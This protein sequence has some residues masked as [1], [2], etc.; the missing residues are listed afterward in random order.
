M[1]VRYRTLALVVIGM[2]SPAAGQNTQQTT[3][4]KQLLVDPPG[5]RLEQPS[6][7][8]QR[9]VADTISEASVSEIDASRNAYLVDRGN[10]IVRRFDVNGDVRLVIGRPQE[11]RLVFRQPW[12]VAAARD[13]ILILD[14]AAT[15]AGTILKLHLLTSSG[16]PR[17]SV[18]ERSGDNRRLGWPPRDFVATDRG[19]LLAKV[20]PAQTVREPR[21]GPFIDTVRVFSVEPSTFRLTKFIDIPVV[22]RYSIGATVASRFME[23][24][25]S[26]AIASDGRIYLNTAGGFVIDVLSRTG[27]AERR[28]FGAVD[29][30]SVT[31]A[32]LRAYLATTQAQQTTTQ[33]RAAWVEHG[34]WLGRAAHRPVIGSMVASRGGRVFV[35]RLDVE[36]QT[37]GNETVWDLINIEDGIVGRLKLPQGVALSKF[38][39]PYIYVNLGPG[40]RW[41]VVRY[42][43]GSAK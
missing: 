4:P 10:N 35:R 32:D 11:R 2:C 39:W 16:L 27:R 18:E 30:I 5:L 21:K 1:S 31:D 26:Y 19:W 13:S 25:P 38:D 6:V 9:G 20:I 29:R 41:Q 3:I 36:S 42:R 33:A 24:H 14:I 12:D 7:L 17:G 37:A 43:I 23:L 22:A 8:F 34:M 28:V 15:A 40:Q